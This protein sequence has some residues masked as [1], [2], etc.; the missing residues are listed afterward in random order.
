MSDAPA[1]TEATE[2]EVAHHIEAMGHSVDLINAEIGKEW[3]EER[4]ST[5]KRN[6]EHLEIMLAK[7]Y[8]ASSNTD[9]KPFTDAISAGKAYIAENE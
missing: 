6:Y 3:S 2:E 1:T 4:G 8:I 9:K 7:E 5:V